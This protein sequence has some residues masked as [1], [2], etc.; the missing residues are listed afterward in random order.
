MAGD[1]AHPTAT[2]MDYPAHERNYSGFLLLFKYGAIFA[3]IA[4]A[5]VI[6]IIS[7]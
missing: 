5:L 2:E 1:Q 4:G 7:H 6:Y 3:A